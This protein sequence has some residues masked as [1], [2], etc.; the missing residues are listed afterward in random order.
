MA[1]I[2]KLLP[3]SVL[4]VAALAVVV[5]AAAT[6]AAQSQRFSDVPPSHE[7]HTAVE[8]AASVG[9]TSGYED[10]TF[11]PDEQLQRWRAK[12]FVDKFYDS[13]LAADFTSGDMM[14]V[15]HQMAGS[16]A[17]VTTTTAAPPA[18]GDET[19]RLLDGL[20]VSAESCGGYSRS[21]YDGY[22][23]DTVVAGWAGWVDYLTGRPLTASSAEVE[24]VVALQE[25]WCSG[26]RAS[27]L[28]GDRDNL[29]L[30]Q[31]SWN[32]SKGGD[33]P[34]EWNSSN[35][36]WRGQPGACRY[37]AVHVKVKA[38]YGMSVDSAEK[39]T[40]RGYWTANCAGTGG[41]AAPPPVTTAPPAACVITGKS[42]SAYDAVP[43][44][45]A[46]LASRLVAGE[47]YRSTADLR[48]VSGIGQVKADAVWSHFC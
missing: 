1:I 33:D 20:S 29:L 37:L 44:I 35:Y 6:A 28:G 48:Q 21:Y 25:A 30:M 39:Q 32:S 12:A 43:G 5:A 22:P 3:R 19:L 46:T 15:L 2:R 27:G 4:G 31:S 18:S 9:L 26:G 41:G 40:V 24:H 7:A 23:S 13:G 8:W 17:S 45:G 11:R 38:K 14:R 34:A 16:P 10:G 42:A 47:P 36:Q